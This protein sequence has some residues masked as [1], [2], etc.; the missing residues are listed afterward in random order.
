MQENAMGNK[1]EGKR[2]TGNGSVFVH[3]V[4]GSRWR[5]YSGSRLWWQTLILILLS[6][7]LLYYLLP[8]F[9]FVPAVNSV[10]AS[11]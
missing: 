6:S 10:L 4:V 1:D 2:I 5:Y 9:F 7:T 3:S 8:L 11:L